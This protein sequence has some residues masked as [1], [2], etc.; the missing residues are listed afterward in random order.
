MFIQ[1]CFRYF[2]FGK[3]LKWQIVG[4]HFLVWILVTMEKTPGYFYSGMSVV[5]LINTQKIK[6]KAKNVYYIICSLLQ[7]A[8]RQMC[9]KQ[10]LLNI[11]IIHVSAIF[12]IDFCV[13]LYMDYGILF[14]YYLIFKCCCKSTPVFIL[15]IFHLAVRVYHFYYM[16]G[17]N[18]HLTP[19]Y[20]YYINGF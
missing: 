2:V 6:V 7:L 5:C 14:V 1:I 16:G 4:L 12:I 13:C 17:M 20:F 15:V 10:V 8:T 9:N 19:V 18:H 3:S 11:Y